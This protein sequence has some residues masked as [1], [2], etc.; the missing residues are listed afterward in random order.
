MLLFL[1]AFHIDLCFRAWWRYV[2]YTSFDEEK[3]EHSQEA[4]TFIGAPVA[5]KSPNSEEGAPRGRLMALKSTKKHNF[6][7][8]SAIN[9]FRKR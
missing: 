8:R 4:R 9:G 5:N 6:S 1:L 3:Q 7:N 2:F